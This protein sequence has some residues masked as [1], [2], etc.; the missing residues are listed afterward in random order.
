[1]CRW[2][3]KRRVGLYVPGLLALATASA[4]RSTVSFI[5]LYLQRLRSTPNMSKLIVRVLRLLGSRQRGSSQVFPHGCDVFDSA[6]A[7]YPV[8]SIQVV[9]SNP[10][11]QGPPPPSTRA[12]PLASTLSRPPS[13]SS[14]QP[15]GSGCPSSDTSKPPRGDRGTSQ[16]TN[17]NSQRPFSSRRLGVCC[18]ALSV[19][20]RSP[21]PFQFTHAI[22]IRLS[23]HR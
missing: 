7:S 11:P 21:P 6:C 14:Q 12:R 10:R 20:L 19:H 15:K 13:P 1:M 2:A 22:P 8:T 5:I 9:I 16:G 4:A 23:S 18:A 17:T 3:G